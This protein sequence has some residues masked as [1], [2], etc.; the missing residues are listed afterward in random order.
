M[1]EIKFF[2]KSPLFLFLWQLRQSLSYRFRFFLAYLVPLDAD[3][4]GN[5]TAKLC[6]IIEKCDENNIPGVYETS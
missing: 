5:I 2:F 4:A 1:K 6:D 3:V